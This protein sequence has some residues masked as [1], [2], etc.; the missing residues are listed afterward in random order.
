M[1]IEVISAPTSLPITYAQAA[2]HLRLDESTDSSYVNICIEDATDFFESE[3]ESSIMPTTL[4][5]THYAWA[6]KLFLPYG[7]VTDVIS[8]TGN[9]HTVSTSLYTLKRIGNT[10]YLDTPSNIATPIVATYT[11]GYETDEYGAPVMP[12]DIRRAIF[13]LTALYYENR[14]AMAARSM[15][16]LGHGLDRVIANHTRTT[17]VR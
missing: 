5:V 1:K 7:P 13:L 11:T 9:G 3:T 12:R 6:P 15:Y 4:Q 10:D 2:E 16:E 14:E 17:V 8:V